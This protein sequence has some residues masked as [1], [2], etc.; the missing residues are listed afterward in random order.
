MDREHWQ[1]VQQ[2]F[3]GALERPSEEV[4]AWLDEACGGDES[5]KAEVEEL[6][7]SDF[8]AASFIRT[9][10]GSGSG[11]P[12]AVA[13]VPQTSRFGKYEI[14]KKIGQG[15]FGVVY[16]GRDP[17]LQR[18]VAVKTCST[19]DGQLR[20]RF[21]REGRIS[22]GLQHPNVTTVHDLGVEDGMPYLVQEFLRGEDLDHVIERREPM[23]LLTKLDYL[24]QIARGLEYAHGAGVL[25]RDIKP[26]N[27]RIQDSGSVKIMDFGIAKVLKDDT[28]LTG[29]GMALGTVGYLAPEQLRGE[30]VDARADIFSFGVLAYELLTFERP[31]KGDN[32]SQVSYQLLYKEPVPIATLWPQ[33]P[34]SLSTVIERCLAKECA[35]RHTDFTAVLAELEPQ[36]ETLRSGSSLEL[37]GPTVGMPS[38]EL[39]DGLPAA[40]DTVVQPA[41]RGPMTWLVVAGLAAILGGA[42]WWVWRSAK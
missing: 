3:E 27:V 36:L 26:A 39:T 7:R 15:G 14:E 21:F 38:E 16:R 37:M 35:D 19:E 29:T 24:V 33:C 41:A 1:E 20:Q 11:P 34:T 22:A 9:E 23:S 2:L 32:F 12:K 6:L 17:M 25:H 10:V 28:G 4:S 13:Q 18:Y 42:A 31:F 40:T 8:E 30:E 5:L